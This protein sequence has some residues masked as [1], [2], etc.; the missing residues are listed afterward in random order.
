MLFSWSKYNS[1]TY[2]TENKWVLRCFCSSLCV[3]DLLQCRQ[4]NQYV[5][6]YAIL[7]H[8]WSLVAMPFDVLLHFSSLQWRHEICIK[9]QTG[10]HRHTLDEISN[11]SVIYH[12]LTISRVCTRMKLYFIY[13][14]VFTLLCFCHNTVADIVPLRFD[15]R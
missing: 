6:H 11:A 7:H 10:K 14:N 5:F 1:Y 3:R 9:T 2:I 13:D 4:H 8:V 12:Q 15:M